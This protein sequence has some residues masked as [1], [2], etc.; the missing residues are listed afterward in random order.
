MAHPVVGLG[1]AK[2]HGTVLYLDG[3]SAKL[4]YT[5]PL[6]LHPSAQTYRSEM[7]TTT[8]RLNQTCEKNRLPDSSPNG[9][10]RGAWFWPPC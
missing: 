4:G 5:M 3:N 2:A 7:H 9:N 6:S 1:G 10:V 8:H